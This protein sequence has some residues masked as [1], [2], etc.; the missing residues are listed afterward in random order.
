MYADLIR[1]VWEVVDINYLDVRGTGFDKQRWAALRD[2][3]L[4][5]RP[6]DSNSAYRQAQHCKGSCGLTEKIPI[7]VSKSAVLSGL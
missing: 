2:E 6:A 3:A 1:E 5:K 4:T 7:R